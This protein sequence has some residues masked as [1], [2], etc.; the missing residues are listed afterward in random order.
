[1]P[2]TDH[3]IVLDAIDRRILAELQADGRLSNLDLSKR[4]HL[5]PTPCLN[6]V[7]RLEKARVILGYRAII[8]P[9]AIDA[10]LLVLVQIVL[11]RTTPAVF[12]DF[13]RAVKTMPEVLECLMVSGGF[14]YLIKARVKD[15]AAYRDFLGKT[16]VRLPS[17]RETHSYVVM[18]RVKDTTVIPVP[19]V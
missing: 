7:R 1:M 14:D 8:E 10:E 15:M 4:V 6:R 18:E 9:M 2:R 5:S 11:D 3:A 17:V 12:D 16:L 19:G 13:A